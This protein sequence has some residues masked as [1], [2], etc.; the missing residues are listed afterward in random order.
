MK[1]FLR[2]MMGEGAN[3]DVLYP[4]PISA[5]LH[6]HLALSRRGERAQKCTLHSRLD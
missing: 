3:L 5:L 2:M 1:A 6:F 4:S